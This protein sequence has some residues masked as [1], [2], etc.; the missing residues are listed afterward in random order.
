MRLFLPVFSYFLSIPCASH[1]FHSLHISLFH[2]VSFFYLFHPPKILRQSPSYHARSLLIWSHVWFCADTDNT[3]MCSH[4]KSTQYL[5]TIFFCSLHFWPHTL[6][7]T[8][9]IRFLPCI[10]LRLN[11]NSISRSEG[12]SQRIKRKKKIQLIHYTKCR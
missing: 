1:V 4:T 9:D 2:S 5:R 10:E 7:Y 8:L 12:K 6:G 11:D 3:L